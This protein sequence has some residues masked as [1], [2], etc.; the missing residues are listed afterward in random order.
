VEPG[1]SIVGE[2]RRALQA[3]PLE[4]K[5]GAQGVWWVEPGELIVGKARRAF[6]A[7]PLES[8]GEAQGV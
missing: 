3:E 1:E 7:E 4:S 2:A 5:G 8:K 6:R